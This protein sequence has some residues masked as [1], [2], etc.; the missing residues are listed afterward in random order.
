M[1][2]PLQSVTI[3]VSLEVYYRDIIA[4]ELNVKSVFFDPSINDQVTKICKPDA[5][6]LGP[7]FGADLKIIL[8]DAKSGL[9]E[10]HDDG[11]VT[12][13]HFR[14]QPGEFIISYTKTNVSGAH[15]IEVDNG[16]V[17]AID[18]HITPKLELEGYARDL[19]RYIQEA[20]KE[21]GYDISDRIQ[22]YIE[23]SDFVEN[24]IQ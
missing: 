21:A 18:A 16:V 11:S 9:F 2:Q 23:Q 13:R 8:E 17:L 10:E 3:G 14:L 1:R 22:L 19:V 12:V 4:E 20:R 15:D 7:K 24:L 6:L 5:K